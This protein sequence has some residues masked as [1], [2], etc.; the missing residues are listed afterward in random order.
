[1][2]KRV[3]RSV[4]IFAESLPT[5]PISLVVR[6]VRALLVALGAALGPDRDEHHEQDREGDQADEAQER[7]GSVRASELRPPWA[8]PAASSVAATASRRG[9]R[10][11][12]ATRRRGGLPGRVF[13]EVE[14]EDVIVID[15]H[16][17]AIL[18]V[19]GECTGDFGGA[20]PFPAAQ[21]GA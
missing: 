12:V 11:G 15:A 4:P 13:D 10:R 17:A 9:A 1:M 16:A 8:T 3:A 5:A 6:V 7:S 18:V 2:V 20:G 14:V 21:N 19:P